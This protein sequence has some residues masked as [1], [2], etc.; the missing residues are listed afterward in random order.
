MIQDK[1]TNQ[2]AVLKLLQDD[3]AAISELRNP[4]GDLHAYVTA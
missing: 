1:V 4:L 2:S 3:P